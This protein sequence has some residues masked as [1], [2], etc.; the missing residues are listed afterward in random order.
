MTP[1]DLIGYALSAVLMAI[2]IGI[3]CLAAI[4]LISTWRNK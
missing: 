1:H 3:L 4:G 2:A